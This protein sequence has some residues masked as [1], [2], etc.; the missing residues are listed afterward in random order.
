MGAR[1]RR[2]TRRLMPGTVAKGAA[3]RLAPAGDALGIAEGIETAL[4]ASALFGVPCWAAVNAGMLAAWQPPAR[5]QAGP[6]LRRQRRELYRPGCGLCAGQTAS[7]PGF[8]VE[9]E[10]P[11]EPEADWNDVHRL[12]RPVP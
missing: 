5:G 10:V 4:S 6:Y 9:V 2:R 11:A 1:H 3:I 12:G 8:I 7:D